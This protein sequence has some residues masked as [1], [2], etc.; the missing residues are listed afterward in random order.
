MKQGQQQ[1]QDQQQ[2]QNVITVEKTAKKMHKGTAEKEDI[3]LK[4]I[5]KRIEDTMVAQ[6]KEELKVHIPKTGNVSG[7]INMEALAIAKG[8]AK[9]ISENRLE[10]WG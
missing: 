3:V 5:S 4:Q 1:V 9:K 8:L 10:E 7:V 6:K 2:V